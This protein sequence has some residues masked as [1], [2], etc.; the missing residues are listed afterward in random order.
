MF[1]SVNW[2]TNDQSRPA[3]RLE[4][5]SFGPP[6]R[7]LWHNGS[8]IFQVQDQ[9]PEACAKPVAARQL[10]LTRNLALP[11]SEGLQPF[12][13]EANAPANPRSTRFLG[14]ISAV[15]E[16]IA[17]NLGGDIKQAFTGPLID[18]NKN[19]RLLRDHD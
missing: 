1:L 4:D 16:L 17:A 18:Q 13:L 8:T 19:F 9:T 6:R 12:R 5:M 3:P 2:P 11:V 7:T 14:V 15:G 10:V